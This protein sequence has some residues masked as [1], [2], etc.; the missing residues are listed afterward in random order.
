MRLICNKQIKGIFHEQLE[1]IIENKSIVAF[2]VFMR[3][4][5]GGKPGKLHRPKRS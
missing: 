2:I 4:Q 5:K 3:T 1:A